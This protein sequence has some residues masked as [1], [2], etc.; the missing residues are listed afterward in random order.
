[1]VFRWV[2][3]VRHEKRLKASRIKSVARDVLSFSAR[4]FIGRY[5]S[6]AV[7]VQIGILISK[8]VCVHTHTHTWSLC[9]RCAP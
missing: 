1:M 6:D 2:L 7:K 3:N 4:G 5:M 8:C 9:S